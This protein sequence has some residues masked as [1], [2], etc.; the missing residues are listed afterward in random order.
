[1]NKDDGSDSLYVVPDNRPFIFPTGEV[2]S[3]RTLR[4]VSH[5]F[6][7]LFPYA[8]GRTMTLETLSDSPKV[9]KL[10]NFFSTDEAEFL[11]EYALKITE[12][13]YRLKRSSTGASGYHVNS[14]RTS[15]NAF[16]STSHVA[17]SLKKRGFSM[18]G[19]PYDDEFGD[20][21]QVLRYNQS[22]AYVSHLDWIDG[23]SDHDYDS[24]ADGT[25]RLATVFLYLSD[26]EEGGAT[27]FPQARIPGKTASETGTSEDARAA[28]DKYLEEKGISD[29]FPQGS[30]QRK[31]VA[32][33]RTLFSVKPKKGDAILFYSQLPDGKV[34][35]LSIHGGCP[36]IHGTK[37]AANLWVWNGPRNG[38]MIRDPETGLMRR[39]R[40]EERASEQEADIGNSVESNARSASFT[41]ID[42]ENAAIYWEDQLWSKMEVGHKIDV[43]TF[44]G[45][46]WN[47]RVNGEHV[48]LWTI[49]TKEGRQFFELRRDDLM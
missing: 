3:N 40:P 7:S 4:H 15:D 36:V 21:L 5:H 32:D 43:N 9:F 29:M 14:V 8:D 16:D 49:S 28:T 20:G 33:C 13:D 25:N 35:N 2:G 17:V 19:M 23:N 6:T 18:L 46:K 1:M 22:T 45:H 44:V 34:D 10:H 39:K 47:I 48:L 38:Y 30:W 37:W 12:E 42:V 24:A 11:I 26:V 31:M 41:S 27:V